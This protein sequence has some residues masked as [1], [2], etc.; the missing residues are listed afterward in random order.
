MYADSVL[1]TNKVQLCN[2]NFTTNLH[3]YD[4]GNGMQ[5]FMFVCLLDTASI[6]NYLGLNGRS[7]GSSF[8]WI[9]GNILPNAWL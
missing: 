6:S 4:Y 9:W 5:N 8:G 1:S 2:V 3:P 7:E